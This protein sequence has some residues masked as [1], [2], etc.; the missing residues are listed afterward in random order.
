MSL[1]Y[2][3]WYISIYLLCHLVEVLPSQLVQLLNNIEYGRAIFG[4]SPATFHDIDKAA[5]DE[6]V[7]VIP[8]VHKG[9]LSL[10][11]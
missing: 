11:E 2:F 8:R 3:D 9:Q 1:L 5:F 4:R 7:I 6:A 10:P